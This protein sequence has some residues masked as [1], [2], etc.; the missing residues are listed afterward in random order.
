MEKE[1]FQDYRQLTDQEMEI[2]LTAGQE[3]CEEETEYESQTEGWWVCV[4]KVP[5]IGYVTDG[6]DHISTWGDPLVCPPG[7]TT[8]AQVAAEQYA[9]HKSLVSE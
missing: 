5:G 9:Y 2:W 8:A 4:R 7:V 1:P 6:A 3:T